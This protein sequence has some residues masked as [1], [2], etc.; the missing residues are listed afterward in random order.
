MTVFGYIYA[1]LPRVFQED[2]LANSS[3]HVSL[4][5]DNSYDFFMPF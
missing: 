5:D 3:C 2:P 4:D 1:P